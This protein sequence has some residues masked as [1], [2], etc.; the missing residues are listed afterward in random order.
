MEQGDV[1]EQSAVLGARLQTELVGPHVLRLED[2]HLGGGVGAPVEAA[3]LEAAVGREVEHAP[4]D[5]LA[6]ERET[7]GE[8]AEVG[9]IL[10]GESAHE[11]GQ[12]REGAGGAEVA[13][14]V[15][16]VAQARGE[17]PLGREGIAQVAEDRV[18][19]VAQAIIDGAAEGNGR[20]IEREE[21]IRQRLLVARHLL[22][23]VVKPENPAQA[24]A[25]VEEQL[26]LLAP[27][28]LIEGDQGRGDLPRGGVEVDPEVRVE[29][30]EGADALQG[31]AIG[32]LPFHGGRQARVIEVLAA[33]G[34]KLGSG[35]IVEAAGGRGHEHPRPGD[36]IE[37]GQGRLCPSERE[38]VALPGIVAA[39]GD[40]QPVG[41]PEHQLGAQCLAP[42]S[43]KRR[44]L[45]GSRTKPSF[46]E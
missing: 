24:L 30:A 42:L 21:I 3:R 28:L 46:S 40:A 37:L 27:L 38:L 41:R 14:A 44:P 20:S 23:E 45:T 9:G 10:E 19:S 26:Q 34:R 4:L 36:E 39:Q 22:I 25:I 5:E 43:L 6:L 31:E 15:F 29:L 8:G 13:L 33:V 7:R 11:R 16:G 12:I 2:A 35:A 1:R 17:R 18:A 32:E